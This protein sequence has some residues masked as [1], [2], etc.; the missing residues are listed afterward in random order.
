MTDPMT[1]LLGDEESAE[2]TLVAVCVG[3][4][5]LGVLQFVVAYFV[6]R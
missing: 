1:R 6:L 3:V 5:F 2:T 4:G